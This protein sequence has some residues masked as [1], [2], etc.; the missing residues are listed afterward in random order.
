[1]TA[2]W[3]AYLLS[4]L[5][6]GLTGGPFWMMFGLASE[7]VAAATPGFLLLSPLF[8]TVYGLVLAG[9]WGHACDRLEYL[10]EG[11]RE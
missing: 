10:D 7:G 5:F 2:K 6:C 4:L 3:Q 11:V 1:M 9:L 8:M